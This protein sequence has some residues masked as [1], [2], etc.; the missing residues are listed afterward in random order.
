[1]IVAVAL[2]SYFLISA[3]ETKL[4]NPDNVHEA[5][6]GLTFVMAPHSNAFF[7]KALKLLT[8]RQL[9]FLVRI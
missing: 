1:V 6:R 4:T 3:R 5:V 9:S 8:Q 7:N 2:K